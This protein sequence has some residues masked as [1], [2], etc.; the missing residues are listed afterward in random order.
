VYLVGS[1]RISSE[2]HQIS[3]EA[4]RALPRPLTLDYEMNDP[5]DVEQVYYRS[6]HYSYAAKGIPIIFFTTGLH[7]DYHAN[8]D[9]VSK[10]EFGK[11]TRVALLVYETAARLANLDH[12][13][14][15]DN[16]VRGPG[17]IR[18]D[19]PTSH[20]FPDNLRQPHRLRDHHPAVA[21]L[22]PDI[23]RF[24]LAI[25]LLF[26]VFRCASSSPRRFSAIFRIGTAGGRS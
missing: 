10:I 15:R 4:N 9:E 12:P 1:D 17:R 5:G 6:D 13:P 16:K 25:G 20:H 26:A 18:A 14:A 23:R 19:P 8:T 24:P 21:V 22:R 7:A 11:L 3:R 2:L